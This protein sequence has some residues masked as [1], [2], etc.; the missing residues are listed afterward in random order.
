MPNQEDG[1]QPTE[2]PTFEE[3]W[4]AM[5]SGFAGSLFNCLERCDQLHLM[6][7]SSRLAMDSKR[8]ELWEMVALERFGLNREEFQCGWWKTCVQLYHYLD[9]SVALCTY[10]QQQNAF[11]LGYINRDI[12][13]RIQ[14][15]LLSMIELTSNGRDIGS[16]RHL[17]RLHVIK[18]LVR[19]LSC[20]IMGIRDL[21]CGALANLICIQNGNG[22]STGAAKSNDDLRECMSHAIEQC[23]G[24]RQLK[25]LLL[26]PQVCECGPGPTKHAAR[27]LLNMTFPAD[28]V[29]CGAK[30]IWEGYIAAKSNHPTVDDELCF[31]HHTTSSW[32]ITYRHGSGRVYRNAAVNWTV[33]QR[34]ALQGTG[35]TDEPEAPLTLEGYIHSRPGI[36]NVEFTV[37][38]GNRGKPYGPL[39]IAHIA[40]WSS[41]QQDKMWGVWEVGSSPDQYK[42]GTGGVFCMTRVS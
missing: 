15:Q 12:K 38:F 22:T 21:V 3:V 37:A 23:R 6:Q 27:V 33:S 36:H 18:Y 1:E 34:G 2:A 25:D 32:Q 14:H 7:V 11:S 28:Q 35:R 26:S 20:T 29:L 19:L 42:L 9:D 17:F 24:D 41:K 30:D 13:E 5:P 4:S 10:V 16:R 31:H 8:D 40:F 39:P